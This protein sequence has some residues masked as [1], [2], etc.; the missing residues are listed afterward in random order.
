MTDHQ[1][2]L[3]GWSAMADHDHGLN[4]PNHQHGVTLD[5]HAHAIVFGI[6]EE[7]NAVNWHFHVDNGAGFGVASAV[8]TAD[9]RDLDITSLVTTVGLKSVKVDVDDLCNVEV[10][11][12][13]KLEITA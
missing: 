1:H 12:K 11:V 10:D 2:T 6:Y 4:L 5:D 9:Q 13:L 7:T 3:T 8:Y